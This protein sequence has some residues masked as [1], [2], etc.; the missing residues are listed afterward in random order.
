MIAFFATVLAAVS[1]PA[2]TLVDPDA[3]QETRDMYALLEKLNDENGAAFGNE[4]ATFR[5]VY[6]G[7]ASWYYSGA[8]NAYLASDIQNIC[9]IQ[10]AISGWDLNE[11]AMTTGSWCD[12][13]IKSIVKSSEMGVICTLTFHENNPVTGN[14]YGDTNI[15]LDDVLPVGDYHAALEAQ[16]AKAADAIA[17]MVRSDGTMVPIL[18][19]PLHE[20]NGNWFWWGTKSS[21]D[22]YIALWKWIVTYLRDTRGLHNILYI[23]NTDKV[24]TEAAYLARWPGDDYVD[25]V[26]CDVYMADTDAANVLTTPLGIVIKTAEEKSK[27]AALAEVGSNATGGMY[28]THLT[29]WWT[30]KVLK[31]LRDADQFSHIS[32][33]AGWA[34]WSAS[35]CFVPYPGEKN[36]D[37]FR[38]FLRSDEIFLLDSLNADA[39]WTKHARLGW[40]NTEN[41][42]WVYSFNHGWEYMYSVFNPVGGGDWL[43]DF[44]LGWLWTDNNLYPYF[45]SSEKGY[46][47]YSNTTDTGLRWFYAY[48]EAKWISVPLS[49]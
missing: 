41:Y 6:P 24:A 44:R 3:T 10:P 11:F 47:Y 34:T 49:Q 46:L 33:I 21:N 20:N 26:S 36:A 42:P 8:D 31:P 30:T 19:R 32:F 14:Y 16:W 18:L 7:G 5:G 45:W 23:Y 35:L 9:G 48:S 17:R 43:Y 40:I 12:A 29:N 39:V 13:N 25:I 28:G 27:P 38:E 1:L 22:K 2:S 4:Y 15:D 37:D